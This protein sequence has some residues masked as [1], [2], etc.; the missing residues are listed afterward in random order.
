VGVRYAHG[1]LAYRTLRI[2][3]VGDAPT[4]F[5]DFG[6]DLKSDIAGGKVSAVL[7]LPAGYHAT[8]KMCLRVRGGKQIQS[9]T[10]NGA[11]WSDFSAEQEVVTIPAHDQG[12]VRVEVAY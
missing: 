2:V 3:T 12:T 1:H 9:V 6:Y 10:L 8:T 4:R 7:H 5:G 11:K